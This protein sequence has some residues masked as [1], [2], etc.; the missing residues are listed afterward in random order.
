MRGYQSLVT[1][2]QQGRGYNGQLLEDTADGI[3][4][5]EEL[6]TPGYGR[7]DSVWGLRDQF[8]GKDRG[9]FANDPLDGVLGIMSHDPAASADYLDP[10]HNDNLDCLVHDR[11]WKVVVDH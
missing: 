5:A 10:A 9:W 4:H 8:S 6:Y 11:D 3:R 7:S 1:L 2:M